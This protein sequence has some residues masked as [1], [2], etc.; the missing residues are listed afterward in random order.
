VIGSVEDQR[1][2][3]RE[4]EKKKERG[5]MCTVADV[6]LG[7]R[8]RLKIGSDTVLVDLESSIVD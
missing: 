2:R 5:G 3:E 7:E 8:P 1:E 4:R 6:F